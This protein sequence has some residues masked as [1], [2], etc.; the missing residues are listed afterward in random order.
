MIGHP[1]GN[2][3]SECGQIQGS[4]SLFV[5]KSF[6]TFRTDKVILSQALSIFGREGAET[7]LR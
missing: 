4:L 1:E 6:L 3:R 5:K 7:G 2:F